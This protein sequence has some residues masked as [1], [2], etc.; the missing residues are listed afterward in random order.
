MIE[1]ITIGQTI[2]FVILI[3]SLIGAVGAI[4][5][6]IKNVIKKQFKPIEDKIE[7]LIKP[8][9]DK[10]ENLEQANKD[11]ELMSIK[12]DLTNF[13]N[14]VEMGTFKTHIQRLNAHELY[15]RYVK[16]GGNSYIH[17]HWEALK[18]EG[19]I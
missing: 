5:F 9:E 8:I 13:I 19:K 10:I 14:D 12:S 2:D 7:N 16:L 15:D 6:A 4:L 3:A 18:K 11:T 17:E 1:N